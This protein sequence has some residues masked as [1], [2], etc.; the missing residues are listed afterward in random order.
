MIEDLESL[1]YVKSFGSTK[2][3]YLASDPTSETLYVVKILNLESIKE[4]ES[5]LDRIE[6]DIEIILKIQNPVLMPI[7]GYSISKSSFIVTDYMPLGS[8]EDL[9]NKKSTSF[10]PTRKMITIYG[11]ASALMNLH[12]NRI[13]HGNLKSSNVLIDDNFEP[14]LTDFRFQ[15]PINDNVPIWYAPEVLNDDEE[16]TNK[17]DVYSF[18]VLLYH[19]LTKSVPTFED[20][21][22]PESIKGR[23]ILNERPAFHKKFNKSYKQLITECWNPQ[24]DQRPSFKIIIRRLMTQEYLLHHV[25]IDEVAKYVKKVFCTKKIREENDGVDPKVARL[26]IKANNGDKKAMYMYAKHLEK[27]H[28]VA[29]NVKLA[30]QYYKM[31]ADS[32]NIKA[33]YAYASLL[34]NKIDDHDSITESAKYYKIAADN[35]NAEAQ[36]QYA[37]MLKN[38]VGVE[39]DLSKAAYYYKLAADQSDPDSAYQYAMM[40]LDG[41]GVKT[42]TK[43]AA[44][45]LKKAA[46]C[47]DP[48]AQFNYAILL[49]NGFVG[50]PDMN[51]VAHYLKLSAD[52]SNVEAQVTYG[53]MLKNGEGIPQDLINAARYFRLAADQDDPDGKDNYELM[54]KL[55]YAIPQD[56]S[57]S[58]DYYKIAAEQGN[59]QAQVS[60]GIILKKGIGV[61]KNLPLS[62]EYFKKSAEKGNSEGQV[63]YGKSLYYGLGVEKNPLL[64]KKYFKLSAK[65]N[66]SEGMC[67]Y[68]ITLLEI[69][70]KDQKAFE[71]LKKSA[72][73][74]NSDGVCQLGLYYLNHND[75]EK[76]VDL[77]KQCAEKENKNG[78]YHYGLYLAKTSKEESLKMIQKAANQMHPEAELYLGHINKDNELVKKAA[79][80]GSQE[81]QIEMGK[82]SK[83][84]KNQLLYFRM[85]AALGNAEAQ[86]RIAQI[87]MKDDVKEAMIMLEKAANNNY[88]EAI[89]F[90]GDILLRQDKR[91][92]ALKW[93]EKAAEKEN[94]IGINY[95]GLIVMES[96]QNRALSMFKKAADLGNGD[97]QCNYARLLNKLN[98]NPVEAK[99][100]LDMAISQNNPSAILENGRSMIDEDAKLIEIE[101]AAKLGYEE[102]EFETGNIYY[103]RKELK[104]A[105]DYYKLA[106]SHQN[107]RDSSIF[108]Y[109]LCLSNGWGCTKD[110]HTAADK[111]EKI[112]KNGDAMAKNNLGVLLH[113]KVYFKQAADFGDAHGKANYGLALMKMGDHFNAQRYFQMAA[114]QG[115]P[116][117]QNQLGLLTNDRNMIKAAADQNYG[118]AQYNYAIAIKNENYQ[119]AVI[120]FH[121]AAEN[122]VKEAQFAYAV[123][124][125]RAI[126]RTR[127]AK[128]YLKLASDQQHI[129]SCYL[130]GLIMKKEKNAKEAGKYL[131]FAANSGHAA[132]QF[133]MGV[134]FTK[135]A[136]VTPNKAQAIQYFKMA[137]EQNYPGAS[138]EVEKLTSK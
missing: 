104:K 31:A 85:A 6:E 32:G 45:Y 46:D 23:I 26:Q 136:G 119:E 22:D 118:I 108:N 5:L 88:M 13:T 56:F 42:N 93:Y 135:V 40:I 55:G 67:F 9:L 3:H 117:A 58:V 37:S 53:L 89:L 47:G 81:A 107:S 77:L 7:R 130:Y 132:S 127:Q 61:E 1:K 114:E 19:I 64:A 82:K 52:K 4:H 76:G 78:M 44:E 131:K 109:A 101:K 34:E 103:R 72:D 59:D 95:V 80:H 49:K 63:E 86:Y 112:A 106:A 126:G 2:D 38:G 68:G 83:T 14:H 113:D 96:D 75:E 60:Y 98:Q 35:G 69:M 41:V 87:L 20:D 57:Q 54:V 66:N 138:S 16:I 128:K 18:G 36:F 25:K 84:T 17:A 99:K 133:A 137:A 121:K 124:L 115:N 100:Y 111:Y 65:Q 73:L 105:F 90:L 71:Y 134:L 43:L 92:E 116:F 15:Q 74:G 24:P 33:Q 62:V 27:G 51:Q 39:C 10:D 94:P 29:K 125:M 123:V 50:K 12:Q 102:A 70:H 30:A 79:E 97:A 28:K 110:T 21:N 122:G 91:D 48:D 11:V 120:Y 8:L 129:R